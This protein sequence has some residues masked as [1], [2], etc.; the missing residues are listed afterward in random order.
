[1]NWVLTIIFMVL[2]TGCYYSDPEDRYQVAPWPGGRWVAP[3]KEDRDLPVMPEEAIIEEEWAQHEGPWDVAKLVDIALKN[4]PETRDS[5]EVARSAAFN[6]RASQSSL[7]PDI[8]WTGE[9]LLQK[10][11]GASFVDTNGGGSDVISANG[12]A[13]VAASKVKSY[14]QWF[15]SDF[16]LSYLLFDFGGREASIESTRQ[17]LF[18]ANWIHNR[19]IQTIVQSVLTNYYT[20]LQAKDLFAAKL[21]DLKDAEENVKAAEGRFAGGVA[22]KLDVLLAK[23]NLSNAKLVLEQQR[24]LVNTSLGQLAT[25]LGLPANL[26]FDVM[27]LPADLKYDQVFDDVNELIATA[28]QERPDLAAAEANW[29][30]LKEQSVATWSSGMPTL[31]F[32]AE[33]QRANNLHNP[34]QNSRFY[35]GSLTL[36]VPLF[37]GFFYLNQ[38]RSSMAA[39]ASAY[40][41][42]KQE[43]ENV[44]L[45]VVT[46]YY[47]FS[48]SVET[49]KFSEEYYSYTKEAYEAAMMSYRS[50]VGTILDLLAAQSALS[51]ARAQRIQARTQWVMALTDVAYSTGQL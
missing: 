8:E 51:N 11:I 38:T 26:T 28:K 39:A 9:L 15:I 25:S 21:D 29:K 6:W 7:Y 13:A 41:A 35:A 48:T 42:W 45:E 17:A 33:T 31:S 44:M 16:S 14:K 1:M 19:N 47:V 12:A 37:N 3:P 27:P 2:M 10:N 5:W 4:N 24:G 36:N 30:Q 22:T 50:G 23:S 49:V 34:L 20:H 43:E 46:S 40:A 32:N 18:S